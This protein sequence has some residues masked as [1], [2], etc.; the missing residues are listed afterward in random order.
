ME[1]AGGLTDSV[2]G[3]SFGSMIDPINGNQGGVLTNLYGLVGH[4]PVHRHRRRRLDAARSR[5]APSSSCRWAA[6]RSCARW[7]AGA[8]HAFGTI[9]VSAIEVAAPALLALLITDVAFGV[10][11]RVVPQLNV[12]AVG[13]PMKVGVALLVVGI[14]LP[15]L[16]G[17]MSGQL[18]TVGL[19][20]AA[21]AYGLSL[22]MA[23]DD[24]TEKATPKRRKESRKKGQ[25]AKSTEINS[26]AVLGASLIALA[27]MG[28]TVIHPAWRRR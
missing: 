3:F 28:P 26:A 1:A 11:S 19:H 22:A 2:A 16:G 20:R 7:W 24:K 6:G 8:E 15:F 14:S 27:F 17:W 25:V 13:F 12:F 5:R 10:V 4:R 9:F 18:A 23:G 21:L